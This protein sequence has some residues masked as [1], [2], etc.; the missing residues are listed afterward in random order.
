MQVAWVPSLVGELRAH[1]LQSMKAQK[2]KK[3]RQDKVPACEGGAHSLVV[4]EMEQPTVTQ[5]KEMVQPTETPVLLLSRDCH[6]WSF[7][8][9]DSQISA[10]PGRPGGTHPQKKRKIYESLT[11]SVQN[12]LKPCYEGGGPKGNVGVCQLASIRV[13]CPPLKAFVLL[14]PKPT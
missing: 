9:V 13:C 12:D 14:C 10:I 3:K 7:V 2:K 11:T 8:D 1:M 6:K 5:A 4:E